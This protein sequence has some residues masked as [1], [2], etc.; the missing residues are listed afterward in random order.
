MASGRLINKF[1][2]TIPGTNIVTVSG[3]AFTRPVMVYRENQIYFNTIGTPGDL[4][5]KFS[6]FT[7]KFTFDTNFLSGERLFIVYKNP[8]I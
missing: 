7:A 5:Y 8:F 1:V 6:A 4:Q 2:N 3:L